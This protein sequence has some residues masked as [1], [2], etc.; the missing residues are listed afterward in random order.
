MKRPEREHLDCISFKVTHLILSPY[1]LPTPEFKVC[2]EGFTRADCPV[3]YKIRPGPRSLE[4][5]T[6]DPRLFL[7][8]IAEFQ[9]LV[10]E[11]AAVGSPEILD[12]L[13]CA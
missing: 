4:G 10:I 12:S 3:K 7:L 5:G 2:F 6:V 11:A 9:V 1:S 13:L 8:T